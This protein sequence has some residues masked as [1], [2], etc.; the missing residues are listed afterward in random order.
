MDKKRIL[1]PLQDKSTR[2]ILISFILLFSII[3]L[4]FVALS[5]RIKM[6]KEESNRLMEIEKMLEDGKYALKEDIPT[7]ISELENDV[8]Y[9]DKEKINESIK[10]GNFLTLDVL[11]E[12]MKNYVPYSYMTNS[13]NTLQKQIDELSDNQDEVLT[14][15]EIYN[16]IYPVGSTFISKEKNPPAYGTWELMEEGRFIEATE[17]DGEGGTTKEAGLPNIV[18]MFDPRWRDS[19]AGATIFGDENYANGAFSL[20]KRTVMYPKAA[21][22]GTY[23]STVHFDAK[24][25][26]TKEDGVTTKSDSDYHVY[27]Q[28]NTVQPK[29]QKMYIYI[30][31]S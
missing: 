17:T 5:S 26:E 21:N 25:G 28:S 16:K 19:S 6:L 29:S 1:K 9:Q 20:T 10:K 12:K 30:R 13:L 7:K 31:I 14:M 24:N 18:G 15:E 11:N 2:M 8:N 22:S 3:S 23:Y 27:G 4:T